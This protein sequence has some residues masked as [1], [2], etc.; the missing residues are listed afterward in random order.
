MEYTYLPNTG[1][2]VS[3]LCLGT[4]N[5][6]SFAVAD[7]DQCTE[8]IQAAF[9][10]GINFIDTANVYSDG[11]SE[12]IVGE[13]IQDYREEIVL[14]TKVSGQ[15]AEHPNGQGLSRRHILQ[16][17][18]ASLERLD[19][20]YIDLY[21]IHRWDWNTPIE[22][23]LGAL[24][25]LVE[26]GKVNYIGASTMEGW[27]FMQALAQSD[28]DN[29]HRFVT[30][31]PEYSL[32][33]RHEERNVLPVCKDQ[34]VGVMPWSPLTGG[35]LSGKYER[36]ERPPA[37]SRLDRHDGSPEEMY[38]DEEWETLDIIR[39]L[40]TE[41]NATPTQVSLA[42]LLEKD[43]VTAPIIGPRTADQL[44]EALGALEVELSETEL[45]RLENPITPRYPRR[46]DL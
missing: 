37:G 30:M 12:E 14:A 2:Q 18:E 16:Q 38:T 46:E 22:E 29:R 17:V 20:D 21:Q 35:F 15:M 26:T 36:A 45:E 33:R 11:E 41:K 44:D 10:A 42:W 39:E 32:I 34:S 13:A 28:L 19:T 24:D 25:H 27:Q 7:H 8:L 43:V 1:V 3:R 31:Q 23:T 9:D 6:G 5:F 4:M 40:A